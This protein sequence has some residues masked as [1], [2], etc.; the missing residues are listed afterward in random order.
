[1]F[2]M[3]V[4]LLKPQAKKR[5]KQPLRRNKLVPRGKFPVM[6]CIKAATSQRRAIF[7]LCK[8]R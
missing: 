5:Q 7:F 4:D 1:M 3:P 8:H 2:Q 6:C